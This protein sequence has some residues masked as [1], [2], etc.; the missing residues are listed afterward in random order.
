MKWITIVFALVSTGGGV[1]L[2]AFKELPALVRA[3]LAV[4]TILGVVIS[5][6]L[7]LEAIELTQKRLDQ[8]GV[9]T[10]VKEFIKREQAQMEAR[11]LRLRREAEARQREVRRSI[12]W[13]II[14]R[15]KWSLALEFST[16]AGRYWPG[17]DQAY[18]LNSGQTQTYSLRCDREGQKVCFGAWIHNN[19]NGG[20]T[21]G[22]GY[23]REFACTNCCGVCKGATYRNRL[24][25][26][27]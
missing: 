1:A 23:K 14:N 9:T 15:T 21:W 19:T 5:V 25:F 3:S 11:R 7:A 27:F 8:L 18:I 17:H 10:A 26:T 4:L 6:P 24:V 12:S 2:F 16:D 20:S 13:T 22:V